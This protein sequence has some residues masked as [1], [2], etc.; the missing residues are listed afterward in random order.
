MLKYIK[1]FEITKQCF[2]EWVDVSKLVG[3]TFI[4][5]V[6][7]YFDIDITNYV[8]LKLKSMSQLKDPYVPITYHTNH[9]SRSFARL[10]LALW[11]NTYVYCGSAIQPT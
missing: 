6:P 1:A 9:I 3:S 7:A 4:V 10:L 8:L 11:E 5:K 2:Y